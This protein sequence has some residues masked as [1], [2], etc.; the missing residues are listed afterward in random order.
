MYSGLVP[1]QRDATTGLESPL[2]YPSWCAPKPGDTA[3]SYGIDYFWKDNAPFKDILVVKSFSR[4]R[5]AANI[6]AVGK[7]TGVT[8]NFFMSDFLDVV[9][10]KQIIKGE[11]EESEWC[12]AKKGANFGLQ[13]Y[14]EKV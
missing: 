7:N 14:K 2:D 11:I 4:G 3:S 5:S 8:Y 12:F 10:Q 1:W 13:L 9:K 6:N